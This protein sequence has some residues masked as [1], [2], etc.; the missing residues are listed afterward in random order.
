MPDFPDDN[1]EQLY[2]AKL[3]YNIEYTKRQFMIEFVLNRSRSGNVAT[4]GQFWAE[5]AA[6]AWNRINREQCTS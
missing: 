2:E 1:Q 3:V 5:E 4:S 6:R